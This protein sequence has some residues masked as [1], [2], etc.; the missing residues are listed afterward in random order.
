[1]GSVACQIPSVS[2]AE[3][4]HCDEKIKA[5]AAS[6]FVEALK[7]YGACRIREHPIPQR[8]ID[9]CFRKSTTFFDRPAWIKA[10]E[11]KYVSGARYVPFASEMIRGEA[12]LDETFEFQ[13]E[14]Y[15]GPRVP[16]ISW[17]CPP[18]E[19]RD[20]CEYVHKECNRIHTTLLK[21]ICSSLGLDQDPNLDL[22][23]I[24]TSQYT[25]F[26]PYY[27]HFP[28]EHG[29]QTLRVPPHI[30]P[31]TL[32]FNFPDSLGGLKVADLRQV[33]GTLSAEAVSQTDE[34]AFIPVVCQPGEFV[35]LAG[36]VLR[37]L[38]GLGQGIKHSVHCVERPVGSKGLHL[39]YWSLPDLD[40]VFGPDARRESVRAYMARV[41]PSA[42]E[43]KE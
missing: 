7:A 23:G 30:D 1:M 13:Y 40:T 25:Y 19:L 36:N 24:H 3:L 5:Q 9:N 14:A 28:E 41:Y 27:Y 34:A 18:Y 38:V 37:K 10:G 39:N 4:R 21:A 22:P 42:F 32:L 15:G 33:K 26:A 6:T 16:H 2:Y 17:K 20:A 29:Q 8:M 43:D 12:H 35:V 11:S 31:T